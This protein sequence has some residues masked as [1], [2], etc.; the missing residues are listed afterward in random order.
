MGLLDSLD[1]EKAAL[2]GH[3]MG[4][5]VAAA[6]ALEYPGRVT[7]LVLEDSAGLGR[8]ITPMLRVLS[9]PVLGELLVLAFRRSIP[10]AIK[11]LVYDPTTI[12]PDL[13]EALRRERAG[14]KNIRAWLRMLRLGVGIGGFRPEVL[15][16]DG[17]PRLEDAN[18]GALGAAGRRGFLSARRERSCAHPQ[19]NV[20]RSS[21]IAATCPTS[22][23]PAPS[24]NLVGSFL[25]NGPSSQ[26]SNAYANHI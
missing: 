11:R 24:T 1:I 7:D 19:R 8:E 15:M 20:A 18:A 4:G 14:P 6:T 16:L 25:T 17:L 13:L 3:S 10:V 2:V 12:P 5:L 22:S 23:T 9:I 26:T 21:R